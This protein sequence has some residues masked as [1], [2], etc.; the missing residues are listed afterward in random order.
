MSIIPSDPIIRLTDLFDEPISRTIGSFNY[1]ASSYGL[2]PFKLITV[3][4]S[5]LLNR[6]KLKDIIATSL[7]E[8][9]YLSILLVKTSISLED[10]NDFVL[11]LATSKRLSHSALN[12]YKNVLLADSKNRCNTGKE[13]AF[14]QT[15]LAM[16]LLLSLAGDAGIEATTFENY[17]R[18]IFNNVLDLDENK[19][20]IFSVFI[21]RAK[22]K[23]TPRVLLDS[24]FG[25]N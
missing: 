18:N 5:V 15:R 19:W 7:H 24:S 23:S 14:N 4:N 20:T 10:V 12:I 16:R 3:K 22:I 9:I 13:W 2:E 21:L 17:D 25:L 1:F 11:D 6:F 8:N